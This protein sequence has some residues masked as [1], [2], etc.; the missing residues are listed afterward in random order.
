MAKI[1]QLLSGKDE[2]IDIDKLFAENP[3]IEKEKMKCIL[4]P[5]SDGI[6]CGLFMSHYFN[7]KVTGFYDGKILLIKDGIS[8]YD[9]DTCFLD[10]EICRE[11]IKSMGHHMLL[12]NS[13][14]IPNTWEN[15]FKECVQPNL[16]RNY[17]GASTFRLK[18]P[19]ATIHFLLATVGYKRKV[20]LP[21]S[22]LC[23]LLFT[24]GTY[25]VMFSYPENVLNWLSFLR[26]KEEGNPLA[27]IFINK[28]TTFEIMEIMD[29]FFRS[30][31]EFS[32]PRQRGDR[33][34]IS[35][36]D[37]SPCNII[38]EGEKYAIE[39]TAKERIIGFIKL[40]SKLT[41][42][43]YKEEHW[44]FGGLQ[45]HVFTK[46]DFKG[47]NWNVTNANFN[48]FIQLNPLSWAMTS[49]QNIEYTLEEPDSLP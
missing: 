23:P 38:S 5:D 27:P 15:E 39:N 48:Q 13:R 16:I 49:G 22:A 9:Y 10:I 40:L 1:Q 26:I 36:T 45:K 8:C 21:Q 33:L 28:K 42:W 18:Y 43:E 31:D 24:D 20:K 17:D 12:Y 29:N 25:K 7:W 11:G 46:N 41:G 19:L 47:N 32:I 4:S 3:W 34:K 44:C 2:Q 14:H 30:R 37:G 6:L 35:N